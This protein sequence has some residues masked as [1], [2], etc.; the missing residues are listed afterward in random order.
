MWVAE[1]RG[2]KAIH[3]RSRTCDMAARLRLCVEDN[4]VWTR[5]WGRVST[6]AWVDHDGSAWQPADTHLHLTLS[7][8]QVTHGEW[9]MSPRGALRGG[10]AGAEAAAS[11]HRSFRPEA[12]RSLMASCGYCAVRWIERVNHSHIVA[13]PLPPPDVAET[14]RAR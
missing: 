10:R 11:S 5:G 7:R 9:L 6:G 14:R 12:A 2:L 1:Q 3:R 8:L 4:D 13:A